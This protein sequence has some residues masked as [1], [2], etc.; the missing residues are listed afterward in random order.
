MVDGHLKDNAE[1]SWTPHLSACFPGKID[2]VKHMDAR[3]CY[4]YW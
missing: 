4:I 3:A 2:S 1:S